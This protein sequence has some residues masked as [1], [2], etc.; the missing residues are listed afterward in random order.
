MRPFTKYC[1]GK[2]VFASSR[3]EVFD[4]ITDHM[5]GSLIH[6]QFVV[7]E[8]SRLR[9]VNINR[10]D[11]IIND[12]NASITITDNLLLGFVAQVLILFKHQSVRPQG[13]RP[14]FP[15][16][17]LTVFEALDVAEPGHQRLT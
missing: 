14:R 3:D 5:P 8:G 16:S 1:Y 9:T 17:D 4:V 7:Y 2:R 11:R 13:H 10:E 12:I 15:G 6:D